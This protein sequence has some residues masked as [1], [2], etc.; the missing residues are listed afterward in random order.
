MGVSIGA[1]GNT[2]NGYCKSVTEW[3]YQTISYQTYSYQAISY[4]TYSKSYGTPNH[5]IISH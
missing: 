1:Q 2:N 3:V 5:Q 4:Q